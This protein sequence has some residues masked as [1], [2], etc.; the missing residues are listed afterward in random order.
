MDHG[1]SGLLVMLHVET[2]LKE[3]TEVLLES[4]VVKTQ[5]KKQDNVH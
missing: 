1:D 2:E 5:L 4:D 3:E